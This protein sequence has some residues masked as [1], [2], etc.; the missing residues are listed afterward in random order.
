M[1]KPTTTFI[2]PSCGRDTLERAIGS[3]KNQAPYLVGVDTK[4]EGPA[5]TRNKLIEQADTDYVSFL[6]D[7]D[8]VT[9][10]YVEKLELEIRNAK[11]R[12]IIPDLI[13]FR[14]YFIADLMDDNVTEDHFI[15]R[16]PEV[17]WG[18]V[19]ISFSVRRQ[20]ALDHPFQTEEYE[21]LRFVQRIEKAGYNVL[22]SKYITYHG[23]H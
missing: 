19:G 6:D 14:E 23:R 1:P 5:I 9:S 11:E 4:L 18:E 3:C 7:D 12:G 16:I 13:I 22:F 17:K 10:D 21:D 20:I 15:W 8:T 2:I